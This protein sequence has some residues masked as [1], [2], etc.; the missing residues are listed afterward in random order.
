[1]AQAVSLRCMISEPHVPL[2]SVHL[3]ISV[4]K[5]ALGAVFLRILLFSSVSSII[6][7]AMMKIRN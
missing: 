3:K 5:V 6:A 1:M 7:S 2:Q 4:D